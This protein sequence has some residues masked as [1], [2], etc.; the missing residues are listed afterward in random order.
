MLTVSVRNLGP[1]SSGTLD[2]KPL[3]VI[4]GPNNSGKSHLTLL[5]YSV[6]TAASDPD[7]FA[8]PVFSHA[9]LRTTSR[10]A[11][12]KQHERLETVS[13]ELNQW[14]DSRPE[15][16]T[17]RRNLPKVEDMPDSFLNVLNFSIAA[18]GK[19][20]AESLAFQLE[21]SFGSDLGRLKRFEAVNSFG[22]TL[23]GGQPATG[24]SL[25]Y[26]LA[27]EKLRG[28]A[29]VVRGLGM[30]IPPALWARGLYREFESER[31]I[32]FL[33]RRLVQLIFADL[34]VSPFYL[35]AARSGFMQSHRALV[36]SALDR[37]TR[38]GLID[39]PKI[40]P[41]NGPVVD[42][43]QLLIQLTDRTY[44]TLF[45]RDVDDKAA[46]VGDFI[47]E[48]LLEGKVGISSEDSPYPE[49][50][51]TETASGQPLLINRTSTMVSELAPLVLFLRHYIN[52]GNLLI[53]EEPEAQLDPGNQR[54]LA[55]VLARLVRADV[56]V[57]ITT[58]SDYLLGEMNNLLKRGDLPDAVR[59][60]RGYGS[61]DYLMKTEINAYFVEET[62]DG[63]VLRPLK[64]SKKNGIDDRQFAEVALS[65]YNESA[66][67][68]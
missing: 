53:I 40:V 46:R 15:P 10:V 21:R 7:T 41:L 68:G 14:L 66:A 22:I 3:T 38:T 60:S 23:R 37:A 36:S 42:F 55:K 28:S 9:P 4:V 45:E 33:V 32:R 12:G 17:M 44:G 51:Y 6:L 31:R 19:N 34:V 57:L 56:R 62:T 18:V 30:P 11:R 13:S 50:V 16:I 49:I 65:L 27:E 5:I 59:E 52:P 39:S 26:R 29:A 25:R 35:P 63:N 67:L 8:G 54:L 24:W 48:Q 43:L 20:M 64:V 1:L 47:E 61:E 2:I 58:H